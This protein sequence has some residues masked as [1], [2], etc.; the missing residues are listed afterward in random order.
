MTRRRKLALLAVVTIALVAGLVVLFREPG[1]DPPF[2]ATFVRYEGNS[3][4]IRI[5]N[6]SRSELYYGAGVGSSGATITTSIELDSLKAY[7]SHELNV[8]VSW[9]DT[10]QVV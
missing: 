3:A 6:K 5:T 1:P 4:V 7:E 10:V 2:T 9:H 8:G